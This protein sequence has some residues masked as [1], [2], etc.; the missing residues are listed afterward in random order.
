[1]RLCVLILIMIVL[2]DSIFAQ[3][4]VEFPSPLMAGVKQEIKIISE[5]DSVFISLPSESKFIS[6]VDETTV[7]IVS[8]PNQYYILNIDGKEYSSASK[9]VPLWISILPPLVAIFLA[10]FTKE[11]ILSILGGLAIGGM[12]IGFYD[13]GVMGILV[14]IFRIIT[15]YIMPTINDWNQA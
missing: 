4:K 14:S 6:T 10:F 11:V 15:D 5:K 8:A 2:T 3:T 1:M 7:S 9:S 12:I 13:D